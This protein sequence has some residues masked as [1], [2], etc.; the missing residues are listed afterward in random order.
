MMEAD[1]RALACL[2]LRTSR[3]LPGLTFCWK[4]C[5]RCK[6]LLLLFYL[7]LCST[8]IAGS[9]RNGYIFNS[10]QLISKTYLAASPIFGA[11]ISISYTWESTWC[12]R[13]FLLHYL[14]TV[15]DLD[16][17]VSLRSI[18]AL[19]CVKSV[20]MTCVYP[21]IRCSSNN[22]INIL[23]SGERNTNAR[24]TAKVIKTYK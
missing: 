1:S 17:I 24:A 20:W 9:V 5:K 13:V 21:C 2:V 22:Q 8:Y 15:C 16:W 14:G 18:L 19:F 3:E 6:L 7:K 12:V 23:Q 11:R 10:F 4:I